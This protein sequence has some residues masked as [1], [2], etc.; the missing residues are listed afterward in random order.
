M[1][2]TWKLTEKKMILILNFMEFLL[3][4]HQFYDPSSEYLIFPIVVLKDARLFSNG[5]VFLTLFLSLWQAL[6]HLAVPV[7]ARFC[8]LK[9]LSMDVIGYLADD[10]LV[11]EEHLFLRL[12]VFID[13]AVAPNHILFWTQMIILSLYQTLHIQF[14]LNHPFNSCSSQVLI[15]Y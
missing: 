2:W 13:P 6:Q 10:Q 5:T 4:L 15:G 8:D 3:T 14:P 7:V 9:I 11:L 12:L 1:I